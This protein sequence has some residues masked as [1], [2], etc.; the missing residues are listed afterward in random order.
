ME[1][2][3]TM[4]EKLDGLSDGSNSENGNSQHSNSVN[5]D[6]YENM[7]MFLR[8][9]EKEKTH[10]NKMI[11]AHNLMTEAMYFLFQFA[12]VVFLILVIAFFFLLPVW[13]MVH[14]R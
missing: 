9:Y 5:D 8:N 14:V 7:K 3:K 10:D 2:V 12:C 1:G 4:P 11:N 6:I 13:V